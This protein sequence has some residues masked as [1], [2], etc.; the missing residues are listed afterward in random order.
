[1]EPG[2]RGRGGLCLGRRIHGAAGACDALAGVAVGAALRMAGAAGEMSRLARL[3]AFRRVPCLERT[4]G[5][6]LDPMEDADAHGRASAANCTP[7]QRPGAPMALAAALHLSYWNEAWTTRESLLERVARQFSRAGL[8]VTTDPGWN[9]FDLEVRPDPW[10]RLRFKTADEEHEGARL[11]NHV[12]V[13][14]RLS[15]LTLTGLAIAA[16]ATV[17]CCRD[18]PLGDGGGADRNYHGE[19]DV[20][21]E[22]GGRVGTP[23]LSGRRAVRAG[24]QPDSARQ[25][26]RGGAPRG[27]CSAARSGVRAG[28][29]VGQVVRRQPDRRGIGAAQ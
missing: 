16:G 20:R 28:G 29:V 25:A 13:R 3:A 2:V 6:Y 21:G 7:R 22:S 23:C 17:L 1:M 12:A 24:T 27:G 8:A 4:D 15:R 5:A 26:D 10:T 18:G 9:D 11:K 19:R 14:V